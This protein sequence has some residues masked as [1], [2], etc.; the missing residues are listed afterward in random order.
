MNLIKG[1]IQKRDG[2]LVFVETA[3]SNPLTLPLSGAIEALG[4]KYVDK[5]VV[6]GFGLSRSPMSQDR[7][8]PRRRLL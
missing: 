4:A 8:S 3:D 5:E 1:K 2:G 6:L 7:M